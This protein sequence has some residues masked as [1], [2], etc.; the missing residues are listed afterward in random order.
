MI[1]QGDKAVNYVYELNGEEFDI[2]QTQFSKADLQQPK[3]GQNLAANGGVVDTEPVS[4]A[5][6][7]APA[8]LVQ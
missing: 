4:E 3:L 1:I 6:V 8:A 2:Q 5:N 7:A